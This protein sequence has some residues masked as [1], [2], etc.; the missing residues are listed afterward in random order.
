MLIVHVVNI[1]IQHRT[2]LK[3]LTSLREQQL[4]LRIRKGLIYKR[5]CW[6]ELLKARN[7]IGVLQYFCYVY[8][9]GKSN[10]HAE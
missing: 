8:K 4:F 5:K 3:N 9:H 1:S 2:V 7:S 10:K 6:D